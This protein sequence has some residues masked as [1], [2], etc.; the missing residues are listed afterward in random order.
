MQSASVWQSL[1]PPTAHSSMS[2]RE[3][4]YLY[5]TDSSGISFNSRGKT[6]NKNA[7]DGNKMC[8]GNINVAPQYRYP[9]MTWDI[10]DNKLFGGWCV[11]RILT[12]KLTL[13]VN[14][15]QATYA[16]ELLAGVWQSL[17]IKTTTQLTDLII[18]KG[19]ISSDALDTEDFKF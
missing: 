19:F 9:Q 7:I 17:S 14:S 8:W 18:F 4:N 12:P 5:S 6:N 10:S 13:I 3:Y 16:L 2:V 11:R 15:S 1:A